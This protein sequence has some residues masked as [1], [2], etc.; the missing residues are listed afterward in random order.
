[1][2][3]KKW[4]C[5]CLALALLTGCGGPAAP[6]GT[7]T[8]PR[9][10]TAA[11]TETPPR[12]ETAP[13]TETAAQTEAPQPEFRFTRENF[14]RL[15]GSTACLPMAE[16]VCSVLLGES[17]EAV[18]DLIHFNRTTQSYRNLMEGSCDLLLASI[19]SAGVFTEMEKAGFQYD[20][21]QL[22]SDAL[23]FLV[24]ESNP[25]E[26][27]TT[28]QLQ[29]IYT[30]QITNWKELGGEDV[31]IIPLQRNEGA[32][33]QALM[34]KLVMGDLEM[35]QAPPEYA[36]GEMGMLM[37][38]VKSYDASAN[39]IG[40]SVFYYAHDMEM[41]RGLKLLKVDGVEPNRETIRRGEYPHLSAY[42][43]VIPHET[44]ADS[45]IR[46]LYEWLMT[47]DGQGLLEREGYVS[48]LGDGE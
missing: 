24:N 4:I 33:S 28:E 47:P 34:R 8:V 14:P 31:P 19:P 25:V 7:E 45:P 22:C 6:G 9:T 29:G 21:E 30:G 27:V 3:V 44:P 12:T 1:M 40:Y 38:A 16:A 35:M 23:V 5:L 2:K 11:G 36:P 10:E 43:C 39:A 32:G 15:D 17:R 20:M 26:N 46:I 13:Q 48:M 18:Q 37:E 41:A 42:Y